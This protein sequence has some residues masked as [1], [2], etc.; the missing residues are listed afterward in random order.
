MKLR[1]PNPMIPFSEKRVASKDKKLVGAASV[2]EVSVNYNVLI[3]M[4]IMGPG[5][6]RALG[7]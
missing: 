4:F 3:S 7:L 5:M 2:R 6:E 1:F